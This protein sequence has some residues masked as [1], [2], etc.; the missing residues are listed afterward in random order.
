MKKGIKEYL[1]F[2]LLII[3]EI[4]LINFAFPLFISISL[5]NGTFLTDFIEFGVPELMLPIARHVAFLWTLIGILLAIFVLLISQFFKKRGYKRIYCFSKI[6]S[7]YSLAII[8]FTFILICFTSNF[9]RIEG[10][11]R[12]AIANF[13]YILIRFS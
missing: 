5:A 8:I 1:M 12:Y 3:L 9:V 6:V 4:I 2:S 11:I 13:F 7:I 10:I